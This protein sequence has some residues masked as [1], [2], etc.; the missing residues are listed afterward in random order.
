[1][2]DSTQHDRIVPT[3]T[4][5]TVPGPDGRPRMEMRWQ[6]GP[7]ATPSPEVPVAA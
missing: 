6:V 2:T 7:V 3:A 4:W 1:M 5:V